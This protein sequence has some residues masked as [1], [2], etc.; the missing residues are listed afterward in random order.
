MGVSLRNVSKEFGAARVIEDVSMDIPTGGFA[1]FVGPSGC[2]K[3]TLLRMIAGLEET[4]GGTIAIEDTDVTHVEP[5]ERGVAM[6]FQSYALYPHLSVFDN[7]AFSLRLAKTPR[8][9]MREMVREA[10]RILK[11]DDHLDKKPSQLSGGQRQRVAIGRAIVR[12]P[13]VFLFD[14]PLSNLDA[15]LRVQMRLELTRLH[16]Q[17]GATMIYVTHDQVEAMTLADKIFV[18]KGGIVQQAGAPLDLYDDPDNRFVAGFIGS[19]AMNFIAADVIGR[20]AGDVVLRTRG[21]EA[22]EFRAAVADPGLA[23]GAEVEIG[24]RPEHLRLDAAGMP[25]RVEVAEE[26]GDVSYLYTRMADGTEIIVERHGS[27]DR[28]DG[29]TVSIATDPRHVLVFDRQGQRLR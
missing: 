19:P 2:G 18:L 11:L 14:E 15:E 10:A 26:L 24:I 21:A 5:A 25:V 1:V 17:I 23:T 13:K 9:K 4:S 8:A 12:Q 6:V 16:R 22:H 7:M 20:D 29:E 3:S 28:L 27:R